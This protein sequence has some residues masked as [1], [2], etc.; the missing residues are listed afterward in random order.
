[1]KS[2]KFKVMLPVIVMIIVFISILFIQI[3][4]IR[5]AHLKITEIN[6]KHLATLLNA[7][8]LKLNVVQVQQWLTDISATRAA[9]GFDDGFTEAEKHAQNVKSLVAELM[10]LKPEQREELEAILQKFEPYYE[11]GKKMA[12]AYIE[13]GPE[14]GNLYMNE[15]DETAKAINS[16]VD[17]FMEESQKPIETSVEDIE[18]SISR[19]IFMLTF[20]MVILVVL[21]IVIWLFVSKSVVNPIMILESEFRQLAENGGDLTRQISFSSRDEIGQLA[22]SINKFISNIRSIITDVNKNS[23]QVTETANSVFE[24]LKKLNADIEDAAATIE[25]LSAGMEETAASVQQV[26]ASSAQ[27]GSFIESMAEKAQEGAN[28]SE[29]ISR[30]AE[31]LKTNTIA[32]QKTAEEIYEKAKSKLELAL[33]QAGAIE[34]ITVLSD[35]VLKISDQTNL[36]ALNATIE[37][38][39]AGEAGK[40]FAVVAG[41]I[42][43]LAEESKVAVSQI[44]KV[45]REVIAS[46]ENLSESSRALMGFVDVNIRNHL[47]NALNTGEQYANDATY[48]NNLVT[49]FSSTAEALTRSVGDIVRA[50]NEITATVNNGAAGTQNLAER[51]T[52]IVNEI[53][54]VRDLM[55]ASVDSAQKLKQAV[56]KFVV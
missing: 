12:A 8:S 34:H 45:T 7:E 53:N 43:K 39:R 5:N 55:Q 49:G 6:D 3:F 38:A 41:E 42:R 16:L 36:L 15:F 51:S 18:K 4:S 20:T 24:N 2:V 22:S 19:S 44:Q 21:F 17:E 33:Q 14:K 35:A 40:G 28:I 48:V 9:Q 23:D 46:V 37:A 50:M 56:A 11:T 54:T 13:G 52:D 32:S 25:E 30:R 1:M 10:V 47:Q 26:N 31:N 29:E 27:M